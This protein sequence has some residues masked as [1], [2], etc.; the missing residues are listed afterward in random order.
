LVGFDGYDVRTDEDENGGTHF[1]GKL[2]F[3]E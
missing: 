3:K 1:I 2:Y